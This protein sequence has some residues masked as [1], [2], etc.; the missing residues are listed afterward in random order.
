MGQFRIERLAIATSM[1]R[2]TS[3]LIAAIL[4]SLACTAGASTTTTTTP[5]PPPPPPPPKNVAVDCLL[6]RDENA[7]SEIE[8]DPASSTHSNWT[9]SYAMVRALCKLGASTESGASGARLNISLQ[10]AFGSCSG[11]SSALCAFKRQ[12]ATDIVLSNDRR[13]IG[14]WVLARSL[15]RRNT[16]RVTATNFTVSASTVQPALF[17]VSDISKSG[18]S[19]GMRLGGQVKENTCRVFPSG[20][21]STSD[22]GT[23]CSG[24]DCT[25]AR[26]LSVENGR[27]VFRVAY[28]ASQG[29]LEAP[30]TIEWS[31][32]AGTPDAN[33]VWVS[34]PTGTDITLM[35]K[36]TSDDGEVTYCKTRFKQADKGYFVRIQKSGD[37]AMFRDLRNYYYMTPDGKSVQT[38]G[39]GEPLQIPGLKAQYGVQSPDMPIRGIMNAA[40]DLNGNL[41]IVKDEL[42]VPPIAD[43]RFT[44][45][46]IVASTY[47]PETR[48]IGSPLFYGVLNSEDYSESQMRPINDAI[49][50]L[51]ADDLFVFQIFLAHKELDSAGVDQRGLGGT[52]LYKLTDSK[53]GGAPFDYLVPLMNDSCLPVFQVRPPFR[54]DKED[55]PSVLRDSQMCAF[56]KPFRYSEFQS[57]RIQISSMHMTPEKATHEFP[58]DLM[59]TNRSQLQ[60]TAAAIAPVAAGP[61]IACWRIDPSIL[62]SP[63]W[64]SD[65]GPASRADECSMG[66]AGRLGYRWNIG[67]MGWAVGFAIAVH[68]KGVGDLQYFENWAGSKSKA[69]S[70]YGIFNGDRMMAA[71]PPAKANDPNY[72]VSVPMMIGSAS[73]SGTVDK[74]PSNQ[75]RTQTIHA[76]YWGYETAD[77]MDSL[78]AKFAAPICPGSQFS[79]DTVSISWSPLILDVAGKG[80]KISRKF[81]RSVAFDIKGTGYQSYI[82]WPTNTKEVAFLVLP[83]QNGK[84]RS[85]NEL[86]GDNKHENGFAKLESFDLNKDGIVDEKDQVFSRL[87]LWFDRNRDGIAQPKELEALASH[88][89]EQI[90]T[91]Y[92]RP[93][94]EPT[95]EGR[96]LSGLYFNFK[97]KKFMNIE[98]HYFNEYVDSERQRLES[99]KTAASR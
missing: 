81:E 40:A 34:P 24:M 11:G 42:I 64:T 82:D 38:S 68:K 49:S 28:E 89:V 50:S 91:D 3:F 83:D 14:V 12:D 96:T 37:C 30:K 39:Y 94:R 63:S 75:V 21:L 29:R 69:P 5:P 73:F 19:L 93:S 78:V 46:V 4:T 6:V 35:A 61:D 1:G 36:A 60:A 13:D 54:K 33:N 56:S 20:A 80:I 86:F 76:R 51:K 16:S 67:A 70:S 88:G 72:S 87:R 27:M 15:D 48:K 99:P 17:K 98:D 2:K 65:S 44:A 97:L 10:A 74:G 8:K 92:R 79:Y 95:A 45:A 43:R 9:T 47:S 52:P 25:P 58:L 41:K 26:P 55:M 31:S 77:M 62:G 32:A 85:V 18:L 71:A 23:Y 22:D 57:G 7:R 53:A 59:T 66:K 84:V 90:R